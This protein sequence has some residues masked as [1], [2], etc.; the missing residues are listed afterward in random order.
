LSGARSALA[1][2]RDQLY[3]ATGHKQVPPL[4]LNGGGDV[5]DAFLTGYYAGDGLKRGNGESVK[6]NSPV[7]AQGLY[8]LYA[9]D[10]RQAS[11]YAEQR[12][13][14]TYYQ[15]N[16]PSAVRVGAKGQHLRRDPAEVRKVVEAQVSDD[17]WVFDLET[18]SGVFC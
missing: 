15:L 2:L 11:V 10:G 3:T 14:R 17:E 6:T 4:I 5:M 12:G 13:P 16:L 8:W 18:E 1:W 7:L 9:L